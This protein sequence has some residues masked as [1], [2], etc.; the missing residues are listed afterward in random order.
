MRNYATELTPLEQADL[1]L[2][3]LNI[4]H[5]THDQG[6]AAYLSNQAP[7]LRLLK[8]LSDRNGVPEQRVK[9]WS[10]PRYHSG[11]PKGS[12]RDMF[13]RNGNHGSEIFIHP[14]FIHYLRYFLFGCE[15]PGPVITAFEDA[16]GTPEMVSS[17]D[18]VPLG[19]A[20]RK[21]VRD[22]RLNAHSAAEEFFKLCLDLNLSLT[23]RSHSDAC[24]PHRLQCRYLP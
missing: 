12:R 6:R 18:V 1:A 2:I 17:S 23:R 11:R 8:S 5:P 24:L 7:I 14:N 10:D 22:Y 16:V 3:D 20:A 19:A 15:L 9:Y 21:L 4:S 13:E